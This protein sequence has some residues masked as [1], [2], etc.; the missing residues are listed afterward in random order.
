MSPNA[1]PCIPLQFSLDITLMAFMMN[2]CELYL[3][4][5][6]EI[7]LYL[8]LLKR[9]KDLSLGKFLLLSV[10]AWKETLP[11]GDLGK[12]GPF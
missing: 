9:W 5:T 7:L 8:C 4:H 10:S 3:H 6:K 1:L 11:I 2:I 12:A